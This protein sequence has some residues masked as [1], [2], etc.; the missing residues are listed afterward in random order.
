MKRLFLA[1]ILVLSQEASSQPAA[2]TIAIGWDAV[3]HPDIHHYVVGWGPVTGGTATISYANLVDV[4]AGT[5]THTIS[6]STC[7]PQFINVRACET[8]GACGPWDGELASQYPFV[9]GR[10]CLA[11]PP[12]QN[13]R[14]TD[15]PA[16]QG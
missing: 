11:M 7:T 6:V 13:L 16:T 1:L 10:H 2:G 12:I 8:S 4:P 9:E 14:R 5:T 3:S 15:V